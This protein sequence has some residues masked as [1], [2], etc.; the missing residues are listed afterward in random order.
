[1]DLKLLPQPGPATE[2]E[3][4]QLFASLGED[5]SRAASIR[6][7]LG[8][9]NA[10]SVANLLHLARQKG[11]AD[12]MIAALEEWCEIVVKAPDTVTAGVD[13]RLYFD[14]LYRDLFISRGDSINGFGPFVQTC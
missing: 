10:Y 13:T 11:Q 1:M 9:L 3:F 12:E 14:I 4:R 2:Q 7:A 6:T 8:E 5:L